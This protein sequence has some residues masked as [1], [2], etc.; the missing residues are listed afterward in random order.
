MVGGRVNHRRHR[1]GRPHAAAQIPPRRYGRGVTLRC[2][3]GLHDLYLWTYAPNVDDNNT[4]DPAF[5]AELMDT[6][7]P[8]LGPPGRSPNGW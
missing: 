7:S 5:D 2:D 6:L 4:M 1:L 3:D 8:F